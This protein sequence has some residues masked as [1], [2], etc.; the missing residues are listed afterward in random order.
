M[1][2][3]EEFKEISKTVLK[4]ITEAFEVI[5]CIRGSTIVEEGQKF[6]YIYFIRE[7]DFAISKNIKM[8]VTTND[9]SPSKI[10]DLSRE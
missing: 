4:K 2:G 7:G 3:V 5:T 8:N 6:D 9:Y 10:M 1:T